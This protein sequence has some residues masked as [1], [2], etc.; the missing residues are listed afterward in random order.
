MLFDYIML[1]GTKSCVFDDLRLF[2]DVFPDE[3]V[4]VALQHFEEVVVN[5]PVNFDCQD[6]EIKENV[7]SM[8]GFQSKGE[9]FCP[10]TT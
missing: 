10:S 4:G 8:E 2:L 5:D 1:F 6:S 3:A 9:F 7:S